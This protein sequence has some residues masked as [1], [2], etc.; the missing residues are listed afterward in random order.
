MKRLQSLLRCIGGGKRPTQRTENIFFKNTGCK[1][2]KAADPIR[3]NLGDPGSFWMSD[4]SGTPEE[5]AFP[6]VPRCEPRPLE[7]RH[8]N[9]RRLLFGP[10]AVETAPGPFGENRTAGRLSQAPVKTTASERQRSAAPRALTPSPGFRK[11]PRLPSV[12][13]FVLQS[14]GTPA[15]RR[16]PVQRTP[17]RAPSPRP[18]AF[19]SPPGSR[20]NHETPILKRPRRRSPRP[21]PPRAGA[22]PG[23]QVSAAPN[24][25]SGPPTSADLQPGQ[26]SS[27]GG[28]SRGFLQKW[29]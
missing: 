7:K 9:P 10:S 16:S 2:R 28:T 11:G 24:S 1:D 14:T 27:S 23:E 26:L 20:P 21:L 13:L 6:P 22:R 15:E 29:H 5:P 18:T 8:N 3:S 19:S 4:A 12:F 17:A 25:A